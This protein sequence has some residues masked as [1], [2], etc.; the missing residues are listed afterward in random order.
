MGENLLWVTDAKYLNEYK[1]AVTFN[2]GLQKVVDLKNQLYGTIFEP[3][4]NIENFKKFNVSDWT[5][6]WDNGADL[7]PE[8]LYYLNNNQ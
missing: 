6:E 3:L 2:D 8:T 4:K 7:A 1:I 5:V